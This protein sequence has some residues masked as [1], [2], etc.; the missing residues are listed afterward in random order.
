MWYEN[1]Y[2]YTLH[3]PSSGQGNYFPITGVD[4]LQLLYDPPDEGW[5]IDDLHTADASQPRSLSNSFTAD[6]SQL[7]SLSSSFSSSALIVSDVAVMTSMVGRHPTQPTL[8][9]H[10]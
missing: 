3:P 2:H 5:F 7:R 9:F 1:I 6:G 4:N 10:E 8:F